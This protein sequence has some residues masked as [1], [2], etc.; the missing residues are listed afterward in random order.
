MDKE[1]PFLYLNHH[2][3]VK[4]VGKETCIPCHADKWH[5]FQHTGMGM[6]FGK[7]NKKISDATFTKH[8]VLFDK[9]LNTYY[10]PFW[11]DSLLFLHEFRLKGRDTVFSR[12]Q[13]INYIVG[14]GHHTNSHIVEENGY[15]TQAPFTYYTQDGHLDFPPGFENGNNNRFSRKI[16][17]ECMSCHNGFPDFVEGSINKFRSVPE[18]IDCE[19]CHGPG[20]I[21]VKRMRKGLV[22]NTQDTID[23]SIVNPKKLPRDL[24]FDLC[25]RCHLQGNMVLKEGKNFYDFKPGMPLTEIMDVF[26]PKYSNS[27]DRFIM[28]SHVDRLKQ[29]ECYVK[30]DDLSC[31]TCH[32]PHISVQKTNGKTFD[33]ACNECHSAQTKTICKEDVQRREGKSCFSCHMPKSGSVDIP[34]VRITDHK[35]QIPSLDKEKETENGDF[36]DLVAIN[37]PNPD[38]TTLIK[39][40]LQQFERFEALHVLLER[41]EAL[42]NAKGL[43]KETFAFFVH[44]YY[45][46]NKK[47]RIVEITQQIDSL[48]LNDYKSSYDNLNA[49]MFY[50]MANAFTEKGLVKDARMYFKKAIR[51][52]P[53]I[54]DFR[55]EYA[56]FLINSAVDQQN[57]NLLNEAQTELQF[58]LVENKLEEKVYTNLGYIHSLKGE[59]NKAKEL[60]LIVLGLNP[61]ET[62]AKINLVGAYV[63]LGEIDKAKSLISELKKEIPENPMVQQMNEAL[64]QM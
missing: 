58:V 1:D 51:L 30:T 9:D 53:F 37:N 55:M 29:S 2:P 28:A 3:D 6:S 43:N 38:T 41:A 31:I 22:V 11:K 26:L 33:R 49:W 63:Q 18:G 54:L 8:S 62:Q 20:E 36:I 42:L 19:R 15:L 44:L 4:Y 47:N 32:N 57:M 5:T 35:I 10:R 16:G 27:D 14:S 21:H 34:H 13:R 24:Q 23:Y 39:A 52:A 45:L 59:F 64:K 60:Y 56:N 50:R 48:Q 61:N 17:L 7:A 12:K 25:S 40:Y 46:Q